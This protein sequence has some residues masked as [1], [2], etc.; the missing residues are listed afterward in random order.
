MAGALLC[1]AAEAM[2]IGNPFGPIS[3]PPV[4]G[5]SAPA[6]KPRFDAVSRGR[7]PRNTCLSTVA[8]SGFAEIVGDAALAGARTTIVSTRVVT[9][10]ISPVAPRIIF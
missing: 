2:G 1:A 3:V 6:V 9:V 4:V 10:F 5:V 7:S 8:A